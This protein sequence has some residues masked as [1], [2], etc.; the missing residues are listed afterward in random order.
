M[1]TR[2]WLIRH[3]A[4]AEEAR[5]R[6]YGTWDIG[7]SA[8]GRAQME[9]VR[10]YLQA[11][12]LAAIYSSPLRRA[13]ESAEIL[14]TGRQIPRE[15]A[16]NLSEIDFGEFEGMTYHEIAARY[17]EL[18]RS[19]MKTPTEV[20]FPGGECFGDLRS[21]SLAA[22]QSIQTRHEGH[23]AA[24][25]TH[26]GVI[27][28]IIAWALQMPDSCV[29]R[30]AQDYGAINRLSITDGVPLVE[31][32]NSSVSITYSPPVCDEAGSSVGLPPDTP[33]HRLASARKRPGR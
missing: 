18:Y 7:L 16:A 15:S 8:T 22:I 23:T 33:G 31:V 24:V 3:G 27:R 28:A 17:P 29:F 30:L 32:L 19:W 2:L 11:E 6:C 13:L 1:I 20:R 21:R 25:V 9:R 4:P 26:G 5:G 12:P 10:E 14:A